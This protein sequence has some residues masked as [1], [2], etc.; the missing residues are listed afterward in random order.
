MVIVRSLALAL[1][2]STLAACASTGDCDR[3]ESCDIR[4]RPCQERVAK[5]VACLRGSSAVTPR[6]DV[7]DADDFIEGR[8]ES[9]D[10][11]PLSD[12]LR[13]HY[14]A[15]HLLRLM[16]ADVKPGQ[17]AA[18]EWDSVAAFFDSETHRVTVLDR[19]VPLNGASSVILL[20][21][22]LVHAQQSRE[23]KDEFYPPADDSRDA[24]WAANAMIEGEAT[25][26]QDLADVYAYGFAP[27]DLDWDGIFVSFE[28]S[29]WLYASGERAIYER[30]DSWFPYA[31]G[32]AYLS[33]A[34][35]K[36]GSAAVKKAV[37]DVPASTREVSAGYPRRA[38]R[39][40]IESLED[41]A[42]P[43]L[44]E[45]YTYLSSERAGAFLFES[46]LVRAEEL[47]SPLPQL[48]ETGVTGDS[49]STFRVG[50]DQVAAFWRVRFEDQD[51]AQAVES[52]LTDLM[53]NWIV[54]RDDRDLIIAAVSDAKLRDEIAGDLAWGP[55]PEPAV[56]TEAMDETKSVQIRCAFRRLTSL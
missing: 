16:P 55:A 25:L 37:R 18:D 51:H 19:G 43:R 39:F 23:T 8:V 47:L 2:L 17:L 4:E 13:D 45:V 7:V 53:T 10:D 14:R 48:V 15:L 54:K 26:Y 38:D 21:H 56:D 32:G 30:V 28:A 33:E 52:R 31:F 34:Y 6:V 27:A 12:D 50:E 5:I 40:A 3:L 1:M 44:P 41:I 9:A 11:Q 49:L 42:I 35:R 46:F 24:S 20:A 29:S 22:E 36:G